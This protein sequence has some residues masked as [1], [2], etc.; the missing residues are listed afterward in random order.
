MAINTKGKSCS[1]KAPVKFKE[2]LKNTIIKYRIWGNGDG[3]AIVQLEILRLSL[4]LP[5]VRG[6]CY[7]SLH[8]RDN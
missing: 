8:D 7:A 5:K 4:K 2:V 6:V 3:G 1:I